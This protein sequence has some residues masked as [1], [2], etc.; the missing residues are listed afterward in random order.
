MKST[1][2][3]SA[4][5]TGNGTKGQGTLSTASSLLEDAKYSYLTRFSDG[6]GT[7][8]EE[9]L[10]AAHAG[11]F[12]MKLA[13]NLQVIGLTP[14]RLATNCE[15]RLEDGVVTNSH[16]VVHG[17]VPGLDRS[18]FDELVEDARLNCPV[19]KLLNIPITTDAHLAE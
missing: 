1:R 16:L 13:F 14:T 3:A 8:P 17:E 4:N 15:I 12:S 7:N 6:V 9:L 11:C 10:A 5:W 19:S 18:K 2:S